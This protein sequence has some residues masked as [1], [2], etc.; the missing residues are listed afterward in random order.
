M[1]RV[2]DDKAL[3]IQIDTPHWFE[4]M[5]AGVVKAAEERQ[6]RSVSECNFDYCMHFDVEWRRCALRY[7]FYDRKYADRELDALYNHRK[8]GVTEWHG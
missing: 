1:A 6:M 2:T 8:R 4:D 5:V 3:Q 7:C